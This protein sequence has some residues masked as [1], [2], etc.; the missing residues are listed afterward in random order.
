MRS[1]QNT[2]VSL[3][4]FHPIR[5]S[6]GELFVREL[7]LQL[8]DAGWRHVACFLSRPEGTVREFLEAPNVDFETVPDAWQFKLAP[9]CTLA[10]VLRRHRPR[11]LHLSFTGALS[12]YPWLA[13]FNGVERVFFTDQGSRPEGFQPRRAHWL[14]RLTSRAINVPLDHVICISDYVL[15]CWQE[16]DRLPARRITRI[17]NSV[18]LSRYRSVAGAEFRRR[19]DIPADAFLVTQVSWV[20][21]EKGFSDLLEAARIVADVNPNV[22]FAFAGEGRH[23]EAYMRQTREMGLQ[24]RVTWTGPLFNPVE[25]GVYAAADAVCQVSR[26]EEAF[27][28]VIAEA[29]SFAKPVIG[30]RTGAIPEIVEHGR[31]GL[32]VDRGDSPAM[33]EAILKLSA[34]PDLCRKLGFAGRRAA[35]EKF[36]IRENVRRLLDVYGITTAAAC[37]GSRTRATEAGGFQATM[38]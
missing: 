23:R 7:S 6:A 2:L 17:Y 26:W 35:E 21:P 32:L 28:W 8:R 33:A 4:G 36:D 25:E 14:R 18:D 31:T 34:N 20:I 24:G 11:I 37:D 22:H 13:R 10:A 30:T 15:R 38:R 29:M 27:G 3:L 9:A 16:E 1:P 19:F 12:P 5:I